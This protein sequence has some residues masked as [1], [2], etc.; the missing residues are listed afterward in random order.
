MLS[1]YSFL[2][3]CLI[4]LAQSTLC[5]SFLTHWWFSVRVNIRCFCGA[6]VWLLFP[7]PSVELALFSNHSSG[8]TASTGHSEWPQQ[9][10]ELGRQEPCEVQ[11][12]EVPS[13]APWEEQPQSPTQAEEPGLSPAKGHKNVWRPGAS[14]TWGEAER[15]ATL[16]P[17]EENAQGGILSVSIN[18]R[19]NKEG[20][21]AHFSIQWQ[22]RRS[23]AQPEHKKFHWNT[24]NFFAYE[25]D[26]TLARVSHRGYGVSFRGDV[27]NPAGCSSLLQLTLLWAMGLDG[28]ASTGLFQPQPFCDSL[29]LWSKPLSCPSFPFSSLFPC[30]VCWVQHQ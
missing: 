30:H 15:A 14:D 21:A 6:F 24:R 4:F 2:A 9:A 25:S 7:Y 18:S 5:W 28:T 27:Q 20:L 8:S 11:Q 1:F 10:G 22:D 3:I 26:W 19:S 23:W 29:I 13:C 16:Q 17:G 12:R